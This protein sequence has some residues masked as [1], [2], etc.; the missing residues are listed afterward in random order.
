[1]SY[2]GLQAILWDRVNGVYIGA[3]ESR[4]DGQAAGS[5]QDRSLP[6]RR[7]NLGN[8]EDVEVD[9]TRAIRFDHQ[10]AVVGPASGVDSP[11]VLGDMLEQRFGVIRQHRLLDRRKNRENFVC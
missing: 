11:V 7:S 5:D 4:K 1:M 9:T 10:I 6:S 8:L 2:G 3:S